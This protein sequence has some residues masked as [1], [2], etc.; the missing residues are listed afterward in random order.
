MEV[1]RT[2]LLIRRLGAYIV[3]MAAIVLACHGL[4]QVDLYLGWPFQAS[5]YLLYFPIFEWLWSGRTPG[6]FAFG[7]SVINGTGG[8]PTLTQ[9]LIR[10]ATRHLEAALGIIVIFIYARSERCQRIGDML[11]RTYVIRS[12][13]LAQLSACL[14]SENTPEI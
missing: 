7:I 11:A 12:K 13:D 6:K 10:G 5:L 4:N 9:S 2:S 1:S 8:S 14:V 3:D